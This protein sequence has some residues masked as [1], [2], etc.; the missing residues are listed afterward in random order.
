MPRSCKWAV[1][2]AL[3]LLGVCGG[4]WGLTARPDDIIETRSERVLGRIVED[5]PREAVIWVRQ[6]GSKIKRPVQRSEIKSIQRRATIEQVY[7]ERSDAIAKGGLEDRRGLYEECLQQGLVE[8]AIKEAERMWREDAT[9]AMSGMTLLEAY[10]AAGET[11]KALAAIKQSE[12]KTPET[13]EYLIAKGRVYLR[14]GDIKQAMKEFSTARESAK[15][16]PLP[17]IGIGEALQEMGDT[18]GAREAYGEVLKTDPA[19]YEAILGTAY[20]Y[21]YD[22]KLDKAAELFAQA[23]GMATKPYKR[24][25]DIRPHLGLGVCAYL[26]GD[27]ENA[28][29]IL[30]D[31]MNLRPDSQEGFYDLGLVYAALG[32]TPEAYKYLGWANQ[33]VENNAR[34]LTASAQLMEL[35][36][37]PEEAMKLAAKAEKLAPEDPYVVYAAGYVTYR[38]GTAEAAVPLLKRAAELAP[39]AREALAGAAAVRLYAKDYTGA[40]PLYTQAL[41]WWDTADIH[42]GLGLALIGAGEAEKAEMELSKALEM[43][44]REDDPVTRRDALNGLGYLAN[45]RG[46][47]E[48]AKR[49]FLEA[50]A[51][52]AS[53]GYAQNALEKIYEQEERVLEFFGMDNAAVPE[54]MKTQTNYGVAA[55]VEEGKLRLS[56]VQANSDGGETTALMQVTQ[57]AFE[58]AG[59]DLYLP[60][61]ASGDWYGGIQLIAGAVYIEVGRTPLGELAWRTKDAKK[62]WSGWTSIGEFGAGDHRNIRMTASR[63]II[64]GKRRPA[65]KITVD[66]RD[67]AVAPASAGMNASGVRVGVFTSATIGTTV[68]LRADNLMMISSTAGH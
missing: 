13:I 17:L 57:G 54:G 61:G 24:G 47:R 2:A 33:P 14:S 64:D 60:A 23:R 22:G 65:I 58:Q 9:S 30:E 27:L 51:T 20:T 29:T 59:M 7:E 53:S 55:T 39:G 49:L 28:K 52:E 18:A 25:R 4:A 48:E 6:R 1:P 40:V 37:A 63:A 56:G 68:D 10:L 12:G 19:S 62:G 31:A 42:A 41:E 3:A 38:Y 44:G 43:A 35:S 66:G 50:L 8:L 26:N 34:A 21:I 46:A 16:N 5:D 36:G 15:G 11:L 67:A 32:K 45:H